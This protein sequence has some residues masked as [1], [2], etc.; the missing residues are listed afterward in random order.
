MFKLFQK[1]DKI[2]CGVVGTGSLGQ[3][4]ARIYANMP[5]VDFAGIYEASPARAREISEK[6]NC[7]AFASLDELAAVLCVSDR[8]CGVRHDIHGVVALLNFGYVAQSVDGTPHCP[9]RQ[10]FSRER[11][12]SQA[13]HLFITSEDGVS[14]VW[15]DPHDHKPHGV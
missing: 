4:H 9:F 14:F 13:H 7:R 5:G 10:V 2:R 3:H 11:A 6:N 15:I 1:T 12:L 8:S